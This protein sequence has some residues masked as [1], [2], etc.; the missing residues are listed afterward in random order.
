MGPE[1]KFENRTKNFC[2]RNGIF[3]IK[4]FGG[5][6]FTRSGMP[7]KTRAGIPD[8]ILCCGRFFVGLELKS[9]SGTPRDDQILTLREIENAGGIAICAKEK[10]EKELRKMLLSLLTANDMVKEDDYPHLFEWKKLGAKRG[11]L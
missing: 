3:C 10:N 2:K 7:I 11:L 1:K 5:Q 6:V 9:D 4:Q 8:L